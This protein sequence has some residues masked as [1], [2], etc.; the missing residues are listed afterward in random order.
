MEIAGKPAIVVGAGPLGAA[1]AKALSDAGAPVAVL[2]YDEDAA[3]EAANAAGGLAVAVDAAD[4]AQGEAAVAAIADAQ[5]PCRILVNC[6]D[7]GPNARLFTPGG[8]SPLEAFEQV[9][10][11]NLITTFN[12][13]RVVAAAMADEMPAD[14]GERGVIVNASSFAAYEGQIG[15]IAYSAAKGAV[16]GMTLPA[17]RELSKHAIRVVAVATGAFGTPAILSLPEKS[18]EALGAAIPFPKRLGRPE[19][20]AHTVLFAVRQSY[21]NGTTIRLD[22]AHRA[23]PT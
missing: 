18:Q 23:P 17:A 1:T 2:D 3:S 21:L 5:G 12:M 8:P 15:Y 19:E 10:R 11:S 16:D 13:M 7:Y 4:A 9:L 20:F 6:S 22:A 14:G